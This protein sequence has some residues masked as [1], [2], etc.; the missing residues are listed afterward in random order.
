[1]GF[2]RLQYQACV[3]WKRWSVVYDKSQTSL[4]NYLSKIY[5]I[6]SKIN[7]LILVFIVCSY[8]IRIFN[9]EYSH[10]KNT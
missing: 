1:M 7:S 10:V 6:K 8:K 5:T 4:I 9:L 3:R 2:Y